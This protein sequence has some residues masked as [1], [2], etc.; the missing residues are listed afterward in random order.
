MIY[1]RLGR[2]DIQI[3]LL[4]LGSGGHNP[5]GQGTGVPESEIHRLIHH[6]LDLGIN[7]FDSAVP[8]SYGDSEMILGRGLKDVSRDSYTLSTKFSVLDEHTREVI[9]EEVLNR[10]VDN[11]LRNLQV[12][13]LD[14]FL[15]AGIQKEDEHIRA[16][17]E[18][19]PML[20]RLLKSG[21]VRHIGTSEHS[22]GDGGHAWLETAV[23]DDLIE[24][25]MVAYNM[26]NQSAE[27]VVFPMC[28]EKQIGTM[29]IFTV[30]NAFSKPGSL[31]D[32]V[33][34]LKQRGLLDEKVPD[35][36]P[37]GWLLDDEE[38]SLVSAAY[39]FSAGNP[40][41]STIMTGTINP[42]HL[43]GNVRT[44]Q[45]PPLPNEKLSRLRDLFGHLSEVVGN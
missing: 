18:I 2:T 43:E 40:A 29:G 8:P 22:G 39:R 11:S 31:E 38:P 23:G 30:R 21:K 36:N 14:L 1:R 33:K 41:L 42:D 12:D 10:T 15:V 27:R 28:I 4:S 13:E 6:A 34:R 35:V 3:S 7:H 17:N 32:T 9:S 24:V 26:M 44:I 20:E 37:L 25:V 19:R 16:L 5:F 45:K